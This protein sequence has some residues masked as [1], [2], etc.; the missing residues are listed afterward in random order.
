MVQN[1]QL[2]TAIT[3]E[4][5]LKAPIS[6]VIIIY[7]IIGDKSGTVILKNTLQRGVASICAA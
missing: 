4:Y 3:L 7:A 6:E 1:D 2:K 5:A